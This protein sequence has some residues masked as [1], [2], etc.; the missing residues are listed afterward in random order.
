MCER[1]YQLECLQVGGLDTNCYI[2]ADTKSNKAIIIDPGAEPEKI[3]AKIKEKGFKPVFI[4]N[5]HGH[6][7]HVGANTILSNAG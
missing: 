4:I 2:F 5:T 3:T 6:Y 1:T 7:D